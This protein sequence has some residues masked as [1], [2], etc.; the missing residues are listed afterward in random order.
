M[1]GATGAA[2]AL[3]FVCQ[4]ALAWFLTKKEYGI[5]AIAISL[6]VFL[7]I[8]RDGG[9]PMVLEQKGQ[10]FDLFAGPVFWMM[11][12]INIS[13]AIVIFLIA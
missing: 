10:R 9:L 13:T 8:L 4:F 7:S 12:A 3:G 5:Y 1:I 11:L 2:K 6:S